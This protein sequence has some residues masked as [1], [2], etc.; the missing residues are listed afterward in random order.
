MIKIAFFV[1]GQTE[2]IFV[3]KFLDEYITLNK[4]ELIVKKNIGNNK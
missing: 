1:E 3:E 4:C 2:R